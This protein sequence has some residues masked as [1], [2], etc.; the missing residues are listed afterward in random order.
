M[1]AIL[2]TS[3]GNWLR[4]L[5]PKEILVSY[6]LDEVIPIL[7][8]AQSSDC[9]VAGFISYE[10]SNAFDNALTTYPSNGLPLVLF[11]LY[12][13]A[14]YLESLPQCNLSGYCSEIK[15]SI[16]EEV[17]CDKINKIKDHI[18]KG[19]S[20]QINYTYSLSGFFSGDTYGLFHSL[21]QC[22]DTDYAA[23]IEYKE[24]AI[25]SASPE[26]FFSL[27]DGVI[28]SM[29][30]KGTI[31]RGRTLDEDEAL[32]KSLK[33][34]EKNKSENIMI[35]DM[36]RNDLGRIA[37]T[38]SI[39]VSEI[40]KLE[41]YKTLWQMTSTVEGEYNGSVVDV[42]RALFPCASITGAPKVKTMELIKELESHPRGIYTGSIGYWTPT[43]NAQFNVAIRTA[44]VDKNLS[45]I[46]YGVG[47]G[48]VW[49]S[50]AKSEYLETLIKADVLLDKNPDFDLLETL[51]WLPNKGI[52]LKERHLERLSLSAKYFDINYNEYQLIKLLE[53]IND[54]ISLKVRILINKKGEVRIEKYPLKVFL[55]NDLI[56]LK[57][58]S[59]PIDKDDIW[60]YHK[61]TNRSVYS[62][63]ESE[64]VDCDDVILWN[65]NE[66]VTEGTF[67]NIAIEK[68]G[69][70]VTPP[71]SSGLLA[72][73]M[74]Q[75]LLDLGEIKEQIITIDELKKTK[76][77]RV[78][79]SVRG[80]CN[81]VLKTSDLKLK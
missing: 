36:I 75:N 76:K 63:A 77:I 61:T 65:I 49:D 78:F 80:I 32:S 56:E 35:V 21:V 37:E 58:A 42:L 5:K 12:E 27:K 47:S 33:N 59:K 52:I 72:G 50:D 11:G 26:L 20:Y 53:N 10:A 9:Y 70:W 23:Y 48:I 38:G 60:L 51:A 45:S 8:K 6:C 7:E 22:Q 40:F 2:K 24:W 16:S 68:N 34:S 81:A 73:V 62:H 19:N 13:S 44:L 31:G 3:S 30:M 15:P 4:L 64:I 17:Y 55:E 66:E 28:T 57:L 41:R 54:E 14:E 1:I 79:N 29:P 71:V 74:R 43:G 69:Q 18:S 25:C 39:S 46:T 67:L